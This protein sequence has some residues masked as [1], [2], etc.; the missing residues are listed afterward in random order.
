MK[1]VGGLPQLK[2]LHMELPWFRERR[3]LWE[4]EDTFRRFLDA[5]RNTGLSAI[6]SEG[7]YQPYL[8]A[9]LNRH[10]ESLKNLQL[11]DPEW[12]DQPQREVLSD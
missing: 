2:E 4:F 9:I 1:L 10:G 11:R 7:S 3:D 6:A 8:Q 5:P 12:P